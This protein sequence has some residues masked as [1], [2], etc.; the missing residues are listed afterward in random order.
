MW[1]SATGARLKL[2]RGRVVSGRV[3]WGEGA[4]RQ[5]NEHINHSKL[6]GHLSKTLLAIIGSNRLPSHY[7]AATTQLERQR[8]RGRARARKAAGETETEKFALVSV[9][10]T[11]DCAK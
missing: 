6:S 3:R 2:T 8:E 1:Q 10:C 11:F 9:S 4:G 5:S 7:G